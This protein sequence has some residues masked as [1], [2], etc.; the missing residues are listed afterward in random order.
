MLVALAHRVPSPARTRRAQRLAV[1]DWF[2]DRDKG[3]GGFAVLSFLPSI[4]SGIGVFDDSPEIRPE[5]APGVTQTIV[6]SNRH[7][8]NQSQHSTRLSAFP[9]Q[10]TR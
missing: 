1:A 7:N 10:G 2:R 5:P 3:Y 9:S 8:H 4:S 6:I